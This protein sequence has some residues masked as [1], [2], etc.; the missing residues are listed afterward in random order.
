M[1]YVTIKKRNGIAENHKIFLN[2]FPKSELQA[3]TT[4]NKGIHACPCWRKTYSIIYTPIKPSRLTCR[5]STF[6]GY[7]SITELWNLRKCY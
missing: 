7:P 5:N 6:N 3:E 2:K 4:D 1:K